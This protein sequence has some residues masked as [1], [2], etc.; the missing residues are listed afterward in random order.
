MLAQPDKFANSLTYRGGGGPQ[1]KN[2]SQAKSGGRG[3]HA[4]GLFELAV[5]IFSRFSLCRACAMV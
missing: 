2:R 1:Q 4:N 3:G 5:T